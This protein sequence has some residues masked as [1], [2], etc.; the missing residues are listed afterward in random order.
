M[1]IFRVIFLFIFGFLALV[2]T[3]QLGT[4]LHEYSHYKDFSEFNTAEDSICLI[5]VTPTESFWGTFE[6][7]KGYYKF[8]YDL[9]NLEEIEAREVYTEIRAYAINAVVLLLFI[10]GVIALLDLNEDI[11]R[12][13]NGLI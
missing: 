13:K 2:G 1:K 6:S 8:E 4:L 3:L 11:W 5:E 10:L 12:L 9:R 7:L